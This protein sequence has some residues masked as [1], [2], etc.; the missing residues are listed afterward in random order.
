VMIENDTGTLYA[1]VRKNIIS[2]TTAACNT[3]YLSSFLLSLRT[4][5]CSMSFG[6]V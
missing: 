5:I 1:S 6:T 4:F 2:K 3:I